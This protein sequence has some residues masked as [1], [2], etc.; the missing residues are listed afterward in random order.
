[1][2]DAKMEIIYP[3]RER[4]N[5]AYALHYNLESI[6]R[7]CFARYCSFGNRM[8]VP[9]SLT[10]DMVELNRTD[11][12]KKSQEWRKCEVDFLCLGIQFIYTHFM[13]FPTEFAISSLFFSMDKTTLV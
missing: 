9:A 6:C 10:Y 8:N 2:Y 1:M 7:Y 11:M 4:M 5:T 3:G 12:S 13:V